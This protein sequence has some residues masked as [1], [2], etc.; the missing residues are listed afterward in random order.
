MIKL[1]SK[2]KRRLFWQSKTALKRS[3]IASSDS[4]MKHLKIALYGLPDILFEEHQITVG[5]YNGIK[6]PIHDSDDFRGKSHNGITIGK[7]NAKGTMD[8][9][10]LIV[11]RSGFTLHAL[12]GSSKLIGRR[13]NNK[14]GDMRQGVAL[15]IEEV[16]M[17]DL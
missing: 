5:I 9:P 7:L 16:L 14:D 12:D 3:K 4:V 2:I 8:R 10:R 13:I 15:F 17:G 1:N 11:H 6:Y